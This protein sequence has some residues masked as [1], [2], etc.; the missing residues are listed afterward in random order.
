MNVD[1][2]L[3]TVAPQ[4]Y[5][6]KINVPYSWWA[7]DTAA[8]FFAHLS[9]KSIVA[10]RCESCGNISVPPRKA[11]P[12]CGSASV[13]EKALEG[14]GTVTGFTV[15]RRQLAALGSKKVPVIFALV[16]LD[17]ADNAFLHMLGGCAPEEVKIG[18][19]VKPVF[20]DDPKGGILDISF[21]EPA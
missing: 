9:E 3:K 12:G 4:V 6:S 5:Q 2:D 14:G 20:A 1:Q 18:M 10:G 21:F 8:A 19:R 7:G 13:A 16:K 17:G 11:C 15:A